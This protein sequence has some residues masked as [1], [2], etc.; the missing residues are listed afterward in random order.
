MFKSSCAFEANERLTG[1]IAVEQSH[2]LAGGV[3][4]P[5]FLRRSTSRRNIF[6]ATFTAISTNL[7]LQY[8]QFQRKA[9]LRELLWMKTCAINQFKIQ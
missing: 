3:T 7:L 5:S 2:S 8:A 4:L 1:T 9:V 6:A